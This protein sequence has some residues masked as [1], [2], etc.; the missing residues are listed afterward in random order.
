MNYSDAQ[1]SDQVINDVDYVYHATGVVPD[2]V[3]YDQ[4]KELGFAVKKVGDVLN[5]QT[6]MEAVAKGYKLGNAV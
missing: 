6:V 4:I 3:L 5:P 1:G 2:D